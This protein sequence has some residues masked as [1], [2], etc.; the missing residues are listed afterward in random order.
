MGWEQ[1]ILLVVFLVLPLLQALGKRQERARRE[2]PDLEPTTL[3]Q[4]D[5]YDPEEP[6]W[7]TK[8][9]LDWLYDEPPKP[10]P[11]PVPPPVNHR[12]PMASSPT[13]SS[14]TAPFNHQLGHPFNH[15]LNQPKHPLDRQLNRFRPME[16]KRPRPAT[17]KLP[18]LSPKRIRAVLR[19]K[20]G[21]RDAL[22]YK[23]VLDAPL[24]LRDQK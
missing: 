19:N 17:A 6:P 18:A 22:V 24:S 23:V 12:S 4:A 1:L 13:A 14:S 20:H 5:E 11:V 21:F 16:P 15:P 7:A 3:P 2:R 9:P 10:Q 8:G